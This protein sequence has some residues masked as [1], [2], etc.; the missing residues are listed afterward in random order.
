M[1]TFNRATILWKQL[2]RWVRLNLMRS[3]TDCNLQF[4]SWLVQQPAALLLEISDHLP[5]ESLVCLSL[6]CR[7][8]FDFFSTEVGKRVGRQPASRRPLLLLL[9]RD[10]ADRYLYCHPCNELHR[11]GIRSPQRPRLKDFQLIGCRNIS[12][13]Y[14]SGSKLRFLFHHARAVMNSHFLSPGAGLPAELFSTTGNTSYSARFFDSLTNLSSLGPFVP[15]WVQS[16]SAKVIGG[17]LF[18]CSTSTIADCF[19]HALRLRRAVEKVDLYICPH[20]YTCAAALR[21]SIGRR[22]VNGLEGRG[23][24]QIQTDGF[25][26]G[27]FHDSCGW[28]LTDC[29][30]VTEWNAGGKW[31]WMRAGWVITITSYHNLGSCRTPDDKRWQAFTLWSTPCTRRER[32]AYTNR[33][34]EQAWTA[35]CGM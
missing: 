3:T 11:V 8:L 25:G 18:L 32:L 7:V 27:S 23:Q 4:G 19:G 15:R 10:I 34:V 20:L 13:H 6:T 9:E 30:T 16:W 26:P 29:S 5:P 1:R 33:S 24:E 31:P 12:W 17:E 22:R 21:E 14:L 35:G 2:S 28:C